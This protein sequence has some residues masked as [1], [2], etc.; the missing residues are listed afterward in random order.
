MKKIVRSDKGSFDSF[1]IKFFA[2]AISCFK[3][4]SQNEDDLQILPSV[5]LIEMFDLRGKDLKYSKKL[6]LNHCR[7]SVQSSTR[8][9]DM[10]WWS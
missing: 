2:K 4:F 9:Q 8:L 7:K 5:F 10:C 3:S 1:R 6:L